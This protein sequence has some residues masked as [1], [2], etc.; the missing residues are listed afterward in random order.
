MLSQIEE[1]ILARIRSGMD[2][3]S[4]QMAV[5]RGVEDI[6]QP[7]VYTSTEAA[8]FTRVTQR[9]FRCEVTI[10][11]DIIFSHLASEGERRKG[12]YLILDGVV[13]ALL[14]QTL[15]LAIDPL[16]PRS[17]KNSTVEALREKGLIAY[18]LELSTSY[19][20]TVAE[21]TTADELL[22]VGLQYYLKPGDDIAD[23]V[24]LVTLEGTAAL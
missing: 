13:R 16:V 6:R 8:K 14:L 22:T 9:S 7:G 19:P 1:A 24:D 21:E 15:G 2:N 10:F 18:S 20:M 5:Q 4:G 3:A 11:V 12:V 23:A 17:W